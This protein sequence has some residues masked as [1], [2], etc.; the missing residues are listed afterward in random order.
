MSRSYYSEY[1]NHCMRFYARHSGT[2][3]NNKTDKINWLAC[4]KGISEF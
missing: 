3:F 4:H 2:T 1:V